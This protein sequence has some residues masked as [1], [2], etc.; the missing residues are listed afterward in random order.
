[1][2]GLNFLGATFLLFMEEEEVSHLLLTL[3]WRL[4]AWG[5]AAAALAAAAA[6]AASRADLMPTPPPP[7][8][9]SVA[10]LLG[11]VRAG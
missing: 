2:Q 1:M 4:Q 10:G 9:P 11:S 8:A 7:A 3:R 5:R 6:V